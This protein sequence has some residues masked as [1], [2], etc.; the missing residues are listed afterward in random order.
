[1]PLH[2][3]WSSLCLFLA[4]AAASG[5]ERF[6]PAGWGLTA[7][8]PHAPS[9]EELRFSTTY[10]D[11]VARRCTAEN[12]TDKFVLT[13][14]S[15][16]VFP[17]PVQRGEIYVRA[18]ETFMNSRQG[19]IRDDAAFTLGEYAGRRLLI[20]HRREK[21][22]R[23]VRLLLVGGTLYFASAEW[24]GG[25]AP[26]AAAADFLA[27]LAV[28]AD[29]SRRAVVEERERW[30]E[31]ARGNFAVRY[32]ASRW[33]RDPTVAPDDAVLLLRLDQLAE[34]EFAVDAPVAAKSME[35]VVLAAARATAER[36]TVRKRG[37]RLQGTKTVEELRFTVRADGANYENH[38][39]FYSGPEGSVQLRA[40]SPEKQFAQVEGDIAELLEGLSVR[41]FQVQAAR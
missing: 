22:H 21:T 29:F 39:Y 28:P 7:T 8:F 14:F 6:A 25:R 11:E 3:V 34:A 26:S 31:I 1:M 38:G 5:G 24:A 17:E 23:E 30:R 33:Y 37:R 41:A 15:Y 18:I 9:E 10:G 16:P 27:S 36:V 13:R 2:A 4:V 40:W 35:E 19:E 20:E 12:G 32:D